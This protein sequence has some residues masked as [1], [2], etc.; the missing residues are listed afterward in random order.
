MN[1]KS[2]IMFLIIFTLTLCS[3][4]DMNALNIEL[5]EAVKTAGKMYGLSF[6]EL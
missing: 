2:I 5:P 3:G 4:T 1:N 6:L